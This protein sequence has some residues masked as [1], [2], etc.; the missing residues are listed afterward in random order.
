LTLHAPEFRAEITH[1]QLDI[2]NLRSFLPA[3]I[4]PEIVLDSLKGI[5]IATGSIQGSLTD[6]LSSKFNLSVSLQQLAINVIEPKTT[7]SNTSA[8]LR[9]NGALES[10]KGSLRL[11]IGEGGVSDRLP[12]LFKD[13]F[14]YTEFQLN[15]V[16][17]SAK[18]EL[19]IDS[20]RINFPELAFTGVSS[21][22]LNLDHP[23]PVG[24]L[25]F[26]MKVNPNERL[27]IWDTLSYSGSTNLHGDVVID[28]SMAAF[29]GE[30]HWTD[31]NINIGSVAAV[32]NLN[33]R[34]PIW[35]KIDLATM[36]PVTTEPEPM[37]H[38][39]MGF[40]SYSSLQSSYKWTMPVFGAIS[41]DSLN[42]MN[43]GISNCSIDAT[44]ADGYFEA[45]S[46]QCDAYGGNIQG[47]LWVKLSGMVPDSLK[48]WFGLQ[49]AGIQSGQIVKTSSQN[50][51]ES[52]ISGD[53]DLTVQGMPGS[54]NFDVYGG[55]D[56]TRIGRGVALDLLQIMDPEGQDEG[57]QSTRRYL[58][59]GWGVKIFS[60]KIRDG[61]VYSYI[62]PTAPP[63]SK[64]HMFLL[65]KIVRLPPQITYGRIP[66]KFFLR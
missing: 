51:E 17:L 33:G 61:F 54:P 21:G 3:D 37:A 20:L 49:V 12:H 63:P 58:S 36:S 28:S 39:A 18:R 55:A 5:I 4:L 48:A 65:S 24:K 23:L 60:F 6:P 40:P 59:Q 8:T 44:W 34:I 22:R 31:V 56:I 16:T 27:T 62:V 53:A 10:I 19:S 25:W 30:L 64:L 41:I 2:S 7:I 14:F 42:M 13:A 46:F 32:K 9:A 35:Q 50:P 47:S 43:Y 52:I 66:I 57:I 29:N 1:S 38:R 45:P 11:L 26:T 15:G